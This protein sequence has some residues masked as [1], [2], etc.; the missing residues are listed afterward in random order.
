MMVA[1][2]LLSSQHDFMQKKSAP[3]STMPE[4]NIPPSDNKNEAKTATKLPV[5]TTAVAVAT[6]LSHTHK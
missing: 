2:S 5:T 6:T 3:I 4:K 1:S